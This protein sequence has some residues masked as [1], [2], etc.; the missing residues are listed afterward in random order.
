MAKEKKIDFSQRAKYWNASYVKYWK[1]RVKEANNN[2]L[3][4]SQ[5]I[6]GDKKT[7][8]DEVYNDAISSLKINK[9]DNIHN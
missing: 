7:S 9:N 2:A 6:D 3:E 5:V 1:E 8:S 4:G